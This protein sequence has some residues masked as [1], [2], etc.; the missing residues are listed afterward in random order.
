MCKCRY[1]VDGDTP[2]VTA[3]GPTGADNE[4]A[5]GERREMKSVLDAII[6]AADTPP[7]PSSENPI[8]QALT[9]GATNFIGLFNASGEAL[10]GLV[11]G[12]L[13]TLIVLLTFMY[14]L[15]TWIG[16]ERMTRA[17]QWSA[18]WAITR[19]TIMP[20]IAVIV[21]TNPMAYSFGVFLPERQKPA[22][23]DSA[24][25][26]VHPV[27]AFFPHANTGEIFVWAGV[28]AG[29]LA[30]APEKYP[31]LAL[32][33]FGTGIIVIFI[34]GIVTEWITKLLIRRQGLTEV[35]D[36]YDRDF[37]RATERIMASKVGKQTRSSASSEG[38]V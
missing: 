31:L 34:R 12:I 5:A 9:W 11:T 33:Y 22:F 27:T 36:E 17:V 7:V 14:A 24:V 21:L 3:I 26:F 23:Y 32:L 16:E 29:V 18:R 37:A 10:V 38:A 8:I 20:V 6:W 25:S 1:R 35:F 15:I 2:L 13:P 19:Y 4:V 28:S 30:Y